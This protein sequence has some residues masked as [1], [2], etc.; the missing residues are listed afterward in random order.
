MCIPHQHKTAGVMVNLPYRKKESIKKLMQE[1]MINLKMMR[2]QKF[3]A[4]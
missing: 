2:R 4:T 1:E 3:K